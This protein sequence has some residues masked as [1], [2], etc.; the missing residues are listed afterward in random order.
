MLNIIMLYKLNKLDGK[1]HYNLITFYPI[2]YCMN[3]VQVKS[4]INGILK[5]NDF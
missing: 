1:K 2:I 3:P 4:T 5:Q